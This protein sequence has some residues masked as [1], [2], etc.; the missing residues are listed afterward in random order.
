MS[1]VFQNL[2]GLQNRYPYNQWQE[3]LGNCDVQLFLGCTDALTAD[4][5]SQRT[6]EVSINVTST[7]TQ[8]GTWRISNYTP[9]Y[10]ETSGVGRRRLLTM[11][12][13]LRMDIDKAL[14]ILRGQKVMEV[15]K[16][17]YSKH[18]EAKKLRD[19]KASAHVPEWRRTTAGKVHPPAPSRQA[20]PVRKRRK[21]IQAQTQPEGSSIKPVT[22][23]S[24]MSK[25]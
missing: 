23:E 3:I 22:K 10:R 9:E 5:I 11:D 20:R 6:G 21:T 25:P 8:L 13:V 19:S 7:A 17:D 4:F 15:D 14:V 2:A 1:C 24:I 18:P 12:E 16:Y